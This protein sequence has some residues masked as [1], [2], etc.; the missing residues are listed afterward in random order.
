MVEAS[1]LGMNTIGI[2]ISAFNALIGN[3]KIAKYDILDI[4][5][6]IDITFKE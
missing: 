2:D 6:E 1:E 5:Q 3:S 4:E